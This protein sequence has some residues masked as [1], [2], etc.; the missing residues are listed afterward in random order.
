M[1]DGIRIGVQRCLGVGHAEACGDDGDCAWLAC[2]REEGRVEVT[3]VVRKKRP[4][5]MLGVHAH[6][7]HARLLRAGQIHES[8]A[9]SCKRR[10]RG[11][12][13]VGAACEAEEHDRP[14]VS[15][16]RCIERLTV[17][18]DKG[19]GRKGAWRRDL[20]RTFRCL[21]QSALPAAGENRADGKRYNHNGAD[22]QRA[23]GHAELRGTGIWKDRDY[24]T[25]IT[26][27]MIR[28]QRST[29][30]PPGDASVADLIR[31]GAAEFE[32]AGL[33]YGHGTGTA[34]DDAAALVFHVLGL[35]HDRAAEAYETRPDARA[36]EAVLAIITERISRRIPAA[37][38]M[39]RMWFAGLEFEVDPRVIV[40]RSPFAELIIAS[41]RPWVDP[42]RIRRVLDLGTG[43][44][45]IAVACAHALPASVVDAVDISAPAL[46]LARRNVTRHGL[47]DRVRVFEGDLYQPIAGRRYDIIV[48]NPPYVS[49]G[50]MSELPREYGH[51]PDVALRAGADGLDVV[52]RI[53]GG[54]ARHL[55]TDGTL[56][57]EVG[58]SDARLEAAFPGVP[59]LWLEFEH[60]GG[61]VFRLTRAE[62]EA[63]RAALASTE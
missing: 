17:L 54:A 44:G 62:L 50:E 60:G 11:R 27:A 43:S 16:E 59:F 46:E 29:R 39:G 63:Q 41:F 38:L 30:L 21:G 19:D 26:H 58:D 24:P 61:G 45:C 25:S 5:I 37:Y 2:R 3:D 40:P 36:R 31:F 42:A 20:G 4:P 14:A 10:K 15:K 22:Q 48:A 57:V 23:C 8:G 12:A 53:L 32:R 49:D 56:F 18:I 7:Q 51:E 6:E 47:A 52:R 55:E 33:T 28:S 35:D 9:C 13:D 34:V 1:V